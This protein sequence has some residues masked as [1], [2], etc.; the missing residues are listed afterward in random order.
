[1]R[2]SNEPT[3]PRTVPG[4]T[5]ASRLATNGDATCALGQ[6]GAVRC[7]GHGLAW[8]GAPPKG[9]AVTVLGALGASRAARGL[10]LGDGFAC[11]VEP[12]GKVRCAG[13]DD[14]GERAGGTGSKANVVSGLDT[15]AEVATVN[16]LVCA[17]LVSGKVACWGAVAMEPGDSD[18]ME[19]V[20]EGEE[21]GFAHGIPFSR[22]VPRKVRPVAQR[23]AR[24]VPEIDGASWLG[25]VRD[26]LCAVRGGDVLCWSRESALAAKPV[27]G[28]AGAVELAGSCA[29]LDDGRVACWESPAEHAGVE[30]TIVAGLSDV[31]QV[32]SGRGFNCARKKD[33]SVW[34]WGSNDLGGLGDGGQWFSHD[35]PVEPALR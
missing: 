15:V 4:V 31:A 24:L 23:R 6:T 25:R 2:Q 34:C 22:N 33:G 28:L 35:M 18:E 5:D 14:H 3:A 26:E 9:D 10:A 11:V 20:L 1:L 8:M 19:S 32:A 16:G 17:R 21:V 30:P 29:L 13:K 27:A 12:E 7:W